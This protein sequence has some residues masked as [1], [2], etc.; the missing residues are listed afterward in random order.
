MQSA[1]WRSRPWSAKSSASARQTFAGRCEQ[2]SAPNHPGVPAAARKSTAPCPLHAGLPHPGR[3]ER[4]RNSI[5]GDSMAG[6]GTCQGDTLNG[7]D[8]HLIR[9]G[10]QD[11]TADEKCS[12]RGQGRG[13]KPGPG[14]RGGGHAASLPSSPDSTLWP[15][16]YARPQ[17][18]HC[19][20]CQE[21]PAFP[22]ALCWLRRGAAVSALRWGMASG[23]PGVV[24][25]MRAPRLASVGSG[26]AQQKWLGVC[27]APPVCGAGVRLGGQDCLHQFLPP[28]GEQAGLL[29]QG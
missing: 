20:A 2:A 7:G 11:C 13:A 6:R 1:P 25:V 18:C 5:A 29:A 12:G 15:S 24:P 8:D 26:G 22:P 28:R 10:I 19:S 3:P 23:S 9:S 17:D 14:Y 16:R 21:C 4:P 27:P